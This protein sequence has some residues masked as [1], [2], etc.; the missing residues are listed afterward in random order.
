MNTPDGKKFSLHRLEGLTDGIYAIAMTLLALSLPLPHVDGVSVNTDIISHFGQYADLFAVYALSFM[1]LGNFWVIQ[2][3]IFKYIKASNI[4]HIWTN[5]GGL[6]FVCLIPFTSSMMGLHN[7]TFFA[8]LIFHAN[9]FLIS[10]FFAL[11]CRV[12]L[13]FPETVLDDYDEVAIR[14]ITRLNLILP[15]VSLTGVFLSLYSPN[16][17]T[18]VYIAVPFITNRMKSGKSFRHTEK[19]LKTEM[20]EESGNSETG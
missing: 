13:H 3:K 18:I 16:W 17:S 8:N 9:V 1:V 7:H 10:T 20:N 4:P 2:L 19:P 6:L 5:L 14:R 11:Q 15:L 12:L